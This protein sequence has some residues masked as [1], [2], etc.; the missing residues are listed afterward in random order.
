MKRMMVAHTVAAVLVIV[1]M[2][3]PFGV[4][5][6]YATGAADGAVDFSMVQSLSFF[7]ARQFEFQIFLPFVSAL[8]ATALCVLSLCRLF[9]PS[10]RTKL[11]CP[12]LSGVTLV[13]TFLP[14]C[15]FGIEYFTTVAM[16]ATAIKS[17]RPTL[18]S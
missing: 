15:L 13:L 6:Y 2:L 9:A 5:G 7:D 8:S 1:L 16:T 17:L 10:S 3:L 18:P 14:L 12:V 11:A 4:R